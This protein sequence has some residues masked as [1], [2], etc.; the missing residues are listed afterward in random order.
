[1]PSFLSKVKGYIF[2]STNEHDKTGKEHLDIASANSSSS[3]NSWLQN[4]YQKC[5][6]PLPRGL[7]VKALGILFMLATSSGIVSA[8]THGT[9]QQSLQ[10]PQFSC[11]TP[12]H[13]AEWEISAL[14][15]EGRF[16][17]Q[18]ILKITIG[19]Q[20]VKIISNAQI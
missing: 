7:T 18:A 6:L 12:Q 8:N 5:S 1:V 15:V 16:L 14:G 20:T 2:P 3:F 11:P 17:Y 9:H 4:L 13:V 19:Y 10:Q